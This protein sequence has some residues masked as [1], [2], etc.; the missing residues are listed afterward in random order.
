[1]AAKPKYKRIL[2][3]LSG[4]A[5]MDPDKSGGLSLAIID[6]LAAEI[7]DVHALGIQI[8]ICALRR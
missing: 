3:K 4:E 5:M 1:M 8:A 2:L 7:K 6:E